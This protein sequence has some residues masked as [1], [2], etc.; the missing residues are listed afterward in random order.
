MVLEAS[1]CT[2]A[3]PLGAQSLALVSS[4]HHHIRPPPSHQFLLI[5]P[6][7]FHCGP[8]VGFAGTMFDHA[9]ILLLPLL[10]PMSIL[11]LATIRLGVLPSPNPMLLV[12]SMLPLVLHPSPI[13][14]MSKHPGMLL[15]ESKV[16]PFSWSQVLLLV[17]SQVLVLGHILLVI[18]TMPQKTMLPGF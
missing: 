4:L 10:P 15:L 5:L 18:S 14:S 11:L 2:W 6:P 9:T 3:W 13:P 16:F 12:V 1:V 7:A 17:W 8:W